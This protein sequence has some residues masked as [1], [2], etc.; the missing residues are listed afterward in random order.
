MKLELVKSEGIAHQSYFLSDNGEAVVIDPRRDCSIYKDLARKNC[1]KT[2]Y[3]LETHRNEDYVIGSLELKNITGPEICHSKELGFKYGDHALSDGETL[4][5]GSLK[6]K[7]LYTP[8]HTNESLCYA[9][10]RGNDTAA[11][12]VFTGDTLFAGSVGRTDLYGRDFQEKQAERLH[13]SIHE[14]LLPLGDNVIVYPG[15]GS[16][17]LCGHNISDQEYTTIGYERKNNP[18]LQLDAKGFVEHSVGDKLLVPPYFGMMEKVN[19]NGPP[20]MRHEEALKPMGLS[21]FEREIERPNTLIVDTR[22]PY[23]FSGSF[24]PGSISIWLE[25][26]SVYPGWIL[27]YGQRLLFV[28]ER[29]DDMRT[30]ALHLWRIGFDNMIGFL[31]NGI[32][33][34]QDGGKAIDTI[35]TI[36]ASELN[37]ELNVKKQFLVDVREPSEWKEGYIDGAERIFV[38][39]LND[40]AH[41]L[42]KDEPITVTCSVGNR[43]SIAASVLKKKGFKQVRNVLGGMTA[44]N[45]LSYP[46]IKSASA[47]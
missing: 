18:Y 32:T 27:N 39:Y 30:V 43:A 1:T 4:N 31:C 7:A 20:P 10:Y 15:H 8:G 6:V 35:G 22:E 40:K 34:W 11:S 19:L 28:N 3:I 36:S 24:I 12:F 9:V 38:G 47:L 44:W 45:R 2:K 37:T 26:T 17:S 42:P 23:A 46:T 16:G 29:R 41:M 33:E 5:V 14:K 21:D 13:G 25:G